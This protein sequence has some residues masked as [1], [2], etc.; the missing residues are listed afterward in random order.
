MGAPEVLSVARI[1]TL[2]GSILVALCSGTNY[3][4]RHTVVLV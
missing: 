2:V 3:V 1:A 4:R